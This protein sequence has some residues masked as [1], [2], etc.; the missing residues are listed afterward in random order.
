MAEF[1]ISQHFENK[2]PVVKSIYERILKEART[3]G[4]V[5]E[6]PKKTSIHLVNKCGY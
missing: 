6:E 1:S 5:T 4:R 2:N 3:F